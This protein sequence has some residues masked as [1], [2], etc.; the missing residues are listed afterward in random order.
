QAKL[1]IEEIVQLIRMGRERGVH[2]A[3]HKLAD[4]TGYERPGIAPPK[5]KAQLIAE[6][7]EYHLREFRRLADEH[8]AAITAS[9]LGSVKRTRHGRPGERRER[10]RPQ[11]HGRLPQRRRCRC[12][13]LSAAGG[14]AAVIWIA[15]AIAI[16][17]WYAVEAYRA[18]WRAIEISQDLDL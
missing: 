6:Q 16:A 3:I 18:I 13:D 11:T 1:D 12:R 8:A 10:R 7:M 2:C 4:E 17:A 15:L 5:T 9:E 14:G